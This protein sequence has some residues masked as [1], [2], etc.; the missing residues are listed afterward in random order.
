M[1][2]HNVITNWTSL[3]FNLKLGTVLKGSSEEMFC[4]FFFV[5]REAAGPICSGTFN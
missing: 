1:I 4:L 5:E 2:V 3:G